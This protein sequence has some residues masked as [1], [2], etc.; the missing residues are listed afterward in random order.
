MAN[1]CFLIGI[2][3]GLLGMMGASSAYAQ[4]HTT[5]RLTGSIDHRLAIEMTLEREGSELY[6]FYFYD[7]IGRALRVHGS[8]SKTGRFQLDE[9]AASFVGK[10]VAEKHLTG[11]WKKTKGGHALPFTLTVE[12]NPPTKQDLPGSALIEE[13]TLRIKRTPKTDFY[14][15]ATEPLILI[16]HPIVQRSRDAAALRKLNRALS[17][18]AI[19][20]PGQGGKLTEDYW[21]NEIDYVLNYNKHSILAITFSISGKG[22]FPEI[23]IEQKLL[24]LKT[25]D[26]IRAIDVFAPKT[27]RSLAALIDKNFQAECK[28]WR[29]EGEK[30]GLANVLQ[31]VHFN[32]KNLDNFIVGEKGLTFRVEYGFPHSIKGAEPLGLFFYPYSALRPYVRRN[33]LL[34]PFY[35]TVHHG[36]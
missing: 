15:G 27:L 12:A 19:Y 2:G 8:L 33:G 4:S 21:L 7:R 16:H 13:E 14:L 30:V 11:S 17:V 22:V 36:K 10:L 25:G 9:R 35:S 1:R 5:M 31:D 18:G 23:L 29:R 28:Y 34:A 26:P 20:H 3:L 6:G 24:N 32:V